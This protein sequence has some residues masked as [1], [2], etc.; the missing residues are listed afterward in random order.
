M[1][2]AFRKI[3]IDVYDEDVL[4][5]SDLIAPDPRDPATV[6]A[7]AKNKSSQVRGFLSKGDIAGGLSTLLMDAPYGPNVDEAKAITFSAI[8]LILNSTKSTDIP[9]IVRVLSQDAQDTLMKYLYK[10]MAI[11]GD[12]EITPSVLLSWHE[13]LTDVA[14]TGCIVRVMTDRRTV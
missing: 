11:Q 2:E 3:D 5:E 6:L 8:A 12:S 13:K 14:G 7:E 10:G 9:A 4:L 1:A